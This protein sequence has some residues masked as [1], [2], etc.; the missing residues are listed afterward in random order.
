MAKEV[1][2]NRQEEEGQEEIKEKKTGNKAWIK[3]AIIGV[4]AVAVVGGGVY[5]GMLYFN[6]SSAAKEAAEP[7]KP[8]I[9]VLWPMDTFIVNLA[10][11]D[12]ER[13]LKL[14][15]QL[16]L[17]DA[18]CAPE[19]D[20]LKPKLRDNVLGL[21]TTKQFKDVSTYEGKQRLKEEI[22]MRLN[23][24]LTRGRIVQVYF[25]DFVVQ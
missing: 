3:W 9:G 25:T 21:L 5:G 19:L 2:K 10:D 7:P 24:L 14:I 12:G 17:S 22:A 18:N 20:Q 16:E 13:Y 23:N 8:V 11:N 1:E 15:L 6:K 4:V